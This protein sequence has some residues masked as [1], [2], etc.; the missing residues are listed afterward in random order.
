MSKI[1]VIIPCY[2]ARDTISRTLHSIAMQSIADEISVYIINDCDGLYYDDILTNFPELD[3]HYIKR[4]KNGG[5]GAARNTGIQ[6]AVADYITFIDADDCFIN[7][8]A[9]EIMLCRI[10][11][12]NADML[13]SAFEGEM[14][15]DNGI[16]IKRIELS[17]TWM[18][19]KLLRRQF[20]IDNNLFF[21]E[22]LRLNEDVEFN[23]IMIDLGAKT[24]EIS[25]ATLLWRDNP[26]SVTHESIYKNKRVFVD[27]VSEYI[28]DC[29][30]RNM[31]KNII[32][33][34]VLQNLVVVYQYYNVVLDENADMA[35]DYLSACKEYWKLCKPIV[36]DVEDE[37]ITKIFVSVMKGYNFIPNLTFVQFLD[38]LRY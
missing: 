24:T 23:Q 4:E 5:C 28:K 33:R 9:L 12:A 13:V 19:G 30:G 7:C 3:I 22:N 15:F 18:H 10:K 31:D 38:E 21:K 20:L 14:R 32:T 37:Y 11:A 8:L 35:G 6:N 26:N 27:A 25:M 29:E 34:R 1:D 16:G 36:A 17:P 2:K